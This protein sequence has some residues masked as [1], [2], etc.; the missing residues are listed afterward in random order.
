L[1]DVNLVTQLL[2]SFASQGAGA[3]PGSNLLREMG[4]KV[5]QA[6]R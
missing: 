3:G 1:V 6:G 4:L 2:E 5:P